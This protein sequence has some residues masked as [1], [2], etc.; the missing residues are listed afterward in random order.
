MVVRVNC[1]SH[2][3]YRCNLV[4]SDQV[5]RYRAERFGVEYVVAHPGLICDLL[6]YELS[7]VT[8]SYALVDNFILF[9]S[10]FNSCV[11]E[12]GHLDV[13]CHY[14]ERKVPSF[15]NRNKLLFI[16]VVFGFIF[17]FNIKVL[18]L[19]HSRAFK[20]RDRL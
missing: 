1:V 10:I 14:I 5:T 12:L 20:S 19:D 16:A 2:I 18:L 17:F 9:Y 8:S 15:R 7:V 13:I 11:L 4:V 3:F 6:G